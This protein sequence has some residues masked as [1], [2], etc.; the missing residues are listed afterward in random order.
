M[1][2]KTPSKAKNSV[3]IYIIAVFAILIAV[4]TIKI[5]KI[6]YIIYYRFYLFN[7]FKYSILSVNHNIANILTFKAGD[8]IIFEL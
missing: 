2:V 5:V 3:Y 4:L 7:S 1:G 6:I 8:I